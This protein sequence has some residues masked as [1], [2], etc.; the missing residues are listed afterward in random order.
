M[1]YFG[2]KQKIS[3]E[4]SQF[5]NNQLKDDQ[6]FV[7]LF[8]GSCNVISKINADRIRIAN[9]KHQY[10]IS[11]WKD[12]QT[13]VALP[14]ELTDV[15]YQY[16]SK[17]LEDNPGLSGFVGFGCSFSGKWLGGYARSGERNYC[18]NA[19]NSTMKKFETL[20]T[21]QFY[22]LDYRDVFIPEGSLVYCDIPYKNTTQYSVKEVG[23]FNHDEFYQWVKDNS[24]KYDIYISEYLENKPAGFGIVWQK[25]SKQDIKNKTGKKAKTNEIV[26][27]Y[28]NNELGMAI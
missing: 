27:Q 11:M 12:L 3:N 17:H 4:L 8:C 26:I 15:Q 20:D 6:P 16:I 9:D 19:Y 23:E 13:G 10:L 1:Q 2:G 21:V 7:D 25:G 28:E 5:L 24:S 18:L 22:N 14:Q